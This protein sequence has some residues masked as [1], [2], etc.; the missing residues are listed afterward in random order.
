MGWAK[1]HTGGGLR[2]I[3]LYYNT[4]LTPSIVKTL[5]TANVETGPKL[6]KH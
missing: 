3:Y 5:A 4:F 6:Q 1:T 2:L